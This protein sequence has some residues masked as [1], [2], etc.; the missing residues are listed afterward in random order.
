MEE[1]I[2]GADIITIPISLAI[3]AW[4]LRS[5]RLILITVL[6]LICSICGAFALVLP[7]TLSAPVPSWTVRTTVGMG[8]R[9]WVQS[10]CCA[11][12]VTWYT[13]VGSNVPLLRQQNHDDG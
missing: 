13:E 4:V 1:D 10:A 7:L 12:C 6:M 11:P 3:L 2:I 9:R 5:C 8:V